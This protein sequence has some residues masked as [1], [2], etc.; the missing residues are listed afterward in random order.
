MNE[1]YHFQPISKEQKKGQFKS[2]QPRQIPLTK[3]DCSLIEHHLRMNYEF[4]AYILITIDEC[5]KCIDLNV[6]LVHFSDW[7]QFLH[8]EE[9]PRILLNIRAVEPV[10]LS[11]DE[12]V[13]FIIVMS[14]IDGSSKSII[15]NRTFSI[16]E[17]SSQS[18]DEFHSSCSST[19]DK[20]L[21]EVQRFEVQRSYGVYKTFSFNLIKNIYITNKLSNLVIGEEEQCVHCEWFFTEMHYHFSIW[22]LYRA[23]QGVY[24]DK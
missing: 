15:A 1:E 8:V 24:N 23:F 19:S 21:T 14:A 9:N 13:E 6:E 2:N 12:V 18:L 16:K 7:S 17:E 20:F 3:V 4:R 10:P 22:E 11:M 5:I